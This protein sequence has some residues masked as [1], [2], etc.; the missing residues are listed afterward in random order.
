VTH[1]PPSISVALATPELPPASFKL[2]LLPQFCKVRR[3]T[4]AIYAFDTIITSGIRQSFS[5]RCYSVSSLLYT[6]LRNG[7]S[8][9]ASA[10]ATD[11]RVLGWPCQQQP[12][13]MPN[14]WVSSLEYVAPEQTFYVDSV[15]VTVSLDAHRVVL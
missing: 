10:L 3:C 9:D 13:C 4:T 8:S 7:F 1:P 11:R 14:K 6:S 15:Q 5:H 2:E 12:S